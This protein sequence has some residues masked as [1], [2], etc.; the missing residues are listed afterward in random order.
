MKKRWFYTVEMGPEADLSSEKF[1]VLVVK[2]DNPDN[3]IVQTEEN[4]KEHF[5]LLKGVDE[6]T[7]WR[8]F[9]FFNK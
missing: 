8:I 6:E 9:N 3:S 4:S 1:R 2:C 5:L 7:A